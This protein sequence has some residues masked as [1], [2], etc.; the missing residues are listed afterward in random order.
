M[1]RGVLTAPCGG[2]QLRSWAA[3]LDGLPREAQRE[4][5]ESIP[6]AEPVRERIA[7]AWAARVAR[8]RPRAEAAE[9]AEY[10]E[11]RSRFNAARAD[12]V[13]ANL[14]LVM[15]M[16]QHYRGTSMTE[17]DLIQEGTFGLMRAI[18][19]F[20]PRRGLRFSTYATHWIRQ[21]ITR[22]LAN[23]DRLIRLPVHKVTQLSRLHRISSTLGVELERPPTAEEVAARMESTPHE[24]E[25]LWRTKTSVVAFDGPWGDN[26]DLTI[27]ERLCTAETV[28]LGAR[29]AADEARARVSSWLAHLSP[30]ERQVVRERFGLDGVEVRSL[31]ECGESWGI[32]H[33][34][35]RQIEVQALEKLR[36]HVDPADLA[37]LLA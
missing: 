21:A 26:D 37:D 15:M 5:L 20:D 31:R 16:A 6:L 24:V 4:V 12:M 30:R 9:Y 2:A 7:S 13:N 19:L 32:S 11:A 23:Q 18:E 35:V 14:R 29:I 22:G 34:R 1:S 36:G 10:L 33:E 28:D 27:G 3:A 17:L 8:G 25:A